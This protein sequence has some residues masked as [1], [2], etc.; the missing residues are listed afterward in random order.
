MIRRLFNFAPVTAA[1]TAW[2]VTAVGVGIA[3]A[4]PTNPVGLAG[5]MPTLPVPG[6]SAPTLFEG[7]PLLNWAIDFDL[8]F[9]DPIGNLMNGIV[10]VVW[11]LAV[12]L[13]YA[14]VALA[15]WVV[16]LTHIPGLNELMTNALGSTNQ[17]LMNWLAPT[18]LAIGA[19]VAYL[20]RRSGD[21]LN[22]LL[23]VAIAAMLGFSLAWSPQ[24]WVNGTQGARDLGTTAVIGTAGFASPKQNQPFDWP[25]SDYAGATIQ[26]SALRKASDASWRG[27]VAYPWCLIEFGS[28]EAC[29]RYGGDVVKL[30]AATEDRSQQIK[31][32]VYPQEGGDNAP[33]S[34]WVKGQEWGARLVIAVVSLVVVLIFCG[35][36]LVLGFAAAGAIIETALHL[37]IGAPFTLSWCIPGWP[38]QVGMRWLESLIGAIVQSVAALGIFAAVLSILTTIY[39]NLDALGGVVVAWVLAIATLGVGITFRHRIASWFGAL[40]GGHGG[41]ALIGAMVI[42]TLTRGVIGAGR[43]AGRLG[44][45]GARGALGRGSSGRGGANG[46][47]RRPLPGGPGGPGA[48]G[49][50]GPGGRGARGNSGPGGRGTPGAGGNTG[51]RG[52]TGTPGRGNPGTPG[53]PGPS[54]TGRR[55]PAGSSGSPGPRPAGTGRPSRRA[56]NASSTPA[57]RAASRPSSSSSTGRPPAPKP[58]TRSSRRPPRPKGGR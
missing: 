24:L 38:R 55:G 52:G 42:R 5:I 13:A 35:L 51:T 56:G 53:T 23:V 22:Q 25:A 21:G 37:I 12:V 44:A 7:V 1:I 34:K 28:L 45:R 11:S 6:G 17:T 32:T 58:S 46:R 20:Q 4:D 10:N 3:S 2:L 54:G 9:A 33:T 29:Q 30:G 40:A 48:R 47:T 36:L 49:N 41:A 43:S 57:R 18:A 27:L 8:G 31:K 16:G 39:S 19:L 15:Q 26:Q 50:S 14:A